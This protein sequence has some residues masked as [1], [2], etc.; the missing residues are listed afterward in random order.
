MSKVFAI[1]GMTL[2]GK[3]KADLQTK[4]KYS[5]LMAEKYDRLPTSGTAS[6]TDFK[7]T[8]KDLP[9]AVT[10]SQAAMVFDPKKIDV[11]KLDGKIGKSDFNV[12]G[13]V[14]NYLGY[15]FGE[16]QP[17]KGN[18]VFKSNLL[19]LNEFMTDTEETTSTDTASYGVVVVP[20]NIDF[21]LQSSIQRVKL[22]DYNMTNAS[23]DII[24]RDGIANLSGLK[25]NMLGGSFVVNGAYNTQKPDQPKYDFA[26]KIEKVSIR[27]AANTSSIIQSYA[28]IAGLVNGDFSTDIK[29][30]GEL[31]HDMMPKLSTVNADG[32]VKTGSFERFKADLR[33]YFVD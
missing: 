10:L 31:G 27:E 6:L 29:L 19:D 17:I 3:V 12:T 2:A 18:V 20:R 14:I 7:Y 11:Q 15:L 9:Y 24:V 30:S 26:L 16:N 21:V 13:S 8:A 22:M 4:G 28:P 32:L 1:E 23:G 33:N 5:D 25:F